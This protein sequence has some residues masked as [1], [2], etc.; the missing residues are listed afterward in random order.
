MNSQPER[1][2]AARDSRHVSPLLK[3]ALLLGVLVH[4]SGFFIFRVISNPLPS[5]EESGAFISLV[6]TDVGGD[7]AEL[8]E[9]A[10]LFDSAPLFI[11]GE[12][13][14]ASEVFASR[15]LRDWQVFPDFEPKIELMDEVRPDRLSLSQVTGVKQPSDMLNFRFWDLFSYFGQREAQFEEPESWRSVALVS[16]M[17]GSDEF[18]SDFDIRLEADLQSEEFAARPS[19]FFL[20]MSA[21]GL[22]MGAPTLTQSSGSDALDAAALEWLIRP[23]TLARLPAGFLELRIFP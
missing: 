12:W 1:T 18:S 16:I 21:P 3:M 15:I 19:E 6:P 2:G 8:T 5:R 23:E 13:S 20:N 7:E 11:P 17:S 22:P 4:L 10:S 14:S 9:Q